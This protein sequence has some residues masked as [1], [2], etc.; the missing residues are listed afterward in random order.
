MTCQARYEGGGMMRCVACRVAWDSD[1]VTGAC[2]RAR[3]PVVAAPSM[4]PTPERDGQVV[5][6]T[7]GAQERLP[8]A[9]GLAPDI[10]SRPRK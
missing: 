7:R 5:V 6:A 4:V 10:F 8:Y 1:D 3:I 2:P 9:S